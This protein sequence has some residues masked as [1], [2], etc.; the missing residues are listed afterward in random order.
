MHGTSIFPCIMRMISNYMIFSKYLFSIFSL[1]ISQILASSYDSCC[2]VIN[3]PIF[4]FLKL[5]IFSACSFWFKN[6]FIQS[7]PL[8]IPC[9]VSMLLKEDIIDI[10]KAHGICSLTFVVGEFSGLFLHPSIF[11]LKN[12]YK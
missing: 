8:Q 4:F 5:I 6:F 2:F 11:L 9:L 1:Q 7:L 12:C 10:E 3:N